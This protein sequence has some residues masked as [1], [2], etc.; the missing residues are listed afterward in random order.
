M[1]KYN[2]AMKYESLNSAK[3]VGVSMSVSTKMAIEICAFIKG[4]DVNK[5]IKV[6]EEIAEQKKPLPVKRFNKDIG[7]R[8]GV[9][10][11]R[12]PKN[13]ALAII[14]VLKNAQSNAQYKGLNSENLIIKFCR[15]QKAAQ[16]YHS[17][18]HR[19]RKVKRCHVEV[20]VEESEK[21]SD[22]KTINKKTSQKE[23]KTDVP[24]KEPPKKVDAPV[25]ED[26][27]SAKKEDLKKED[28]KSAKKVDLKKEDKKS[29]KKVDLKKEEEK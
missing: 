8:T 12:Y 4:M 22:K 11:G 3:A 20:I 16:N 28:K 13:A 23:A 1:A 17:G 10:P 24:L 5:A 2:Y 15:T 29:A 9:G 25:K 6:L 27:K 18:R 7:H 21:K 26:K 19:G 14:K